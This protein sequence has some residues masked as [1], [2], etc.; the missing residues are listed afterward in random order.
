MVNL[1]TIIR[2]DS[3]ITLSISLADLEF[4]EHHSEV[5]ALIVNAYET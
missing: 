3:V 5:I 2:R 1:I 4:A